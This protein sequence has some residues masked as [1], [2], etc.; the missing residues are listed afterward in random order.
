MI[1][2]AVIGVVAALTIP[3]LVQKHQEKVTVTKVKKF[4]S[5]MSQAIKLA[6]ID[7][8]EIASWGLMPA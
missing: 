2:L 1:T 6:E 8:G 7:N 5:V 4:V 3:T